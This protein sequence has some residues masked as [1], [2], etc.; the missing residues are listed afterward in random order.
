M[1][2]IAVRI[3]E[4]S[5]ADKLQLLNWASQLGYKISKIR[6]GKYMIFFPESKEVNY[7]ESCDVIAGTIEYDKDVLIDLLGVGKDE[8]KEHL[9]KIIEYVECF[10][11]CEG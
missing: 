5:Q 3:S 11:T 7:Y 9:I 2:K 10:E 8:P 1:E 4:A 6:V